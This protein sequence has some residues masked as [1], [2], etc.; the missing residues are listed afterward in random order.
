MADKQSEEFL[1]GF[2]CGWCLVI[3]MMRDR[4]IDELPHPT[5]VGMVKFADASEAY[6]QSSGLG[7]LL[8]P[9]QTPEIRQ[10]L[11][12]DMLKHKP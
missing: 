9:Y 5:G 4:G 6:F 11:L 12:N 1:Q 7:E 10:A 2:A 8:G 3:D